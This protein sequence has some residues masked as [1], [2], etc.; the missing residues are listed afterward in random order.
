MLS[1]LIVVLLVLVVGGVSPTTAEQAPQIGHCNVSMVVMLHPL[2]AQ[3][4]TATGRFRSSALPNGA[5]LVGQA[6]IELEE[7]RREALKETDG[8]RQEL[9]KANQEFISKLHELNR[10]REKS[11]KAGQN[12][13]SPTP[14]TDEYSNKRRA[15]EHEHRQKILAIREKLAFKESAL[16]KLNSEARLSDL[17]SVTDTERVFKLILDDVSE[18]VAIVIEREKLAFTFNSATSY[19][20]TMPT[21]RGGS[22]E[23]P[24]SAL[25]RSQ[26]PAQPGTDQEYAELSRLTRWATGE[27]SMLYHCGDG[28]LTQFVLKGG[29]DIT[30]AVIA[31]V[32]KK[33]QVPSGACDVVQKLFRTGIMNK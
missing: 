25:L 21:A 4:D 31:E 9:A 24:I 10:E 1:R 18:A 6:A 2:M 27:K 14:S 23:N 12:K 22:V 15:L 8:L 5:T 29:K 16:E 19:R 3:I 17:L 20:F 30:P 32:Y 7:Q 33:H 26:K 11:P 13:S 28:R